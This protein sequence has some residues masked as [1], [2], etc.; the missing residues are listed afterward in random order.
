MPVCGT[1]RHKTG[2]YCP[3][4]GRSYDYDTKAC[5]NYSGVGESSRKTCGMCANGVNDGAYVTCRVH[6]SR[7]NIDM[8][9]CEYYR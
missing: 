7:F 2:A 5:E 9:S 1:C 4:Y 6:N 8:A 3:V